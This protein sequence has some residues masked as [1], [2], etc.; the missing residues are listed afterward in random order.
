M[1]MLLVKTN[2]EVVKLLTLLVDGATEEWLYGPVGELGEHSVPLRVTYDVKVAMVTG[3]VMVVV[4][5]V[6][7]WALAAPTEKA[8]INK[9]LIRESPPIVESPRQKERN[10]GSKGQ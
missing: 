4:T 10:L 8:P 2:V 6:V 7:V 9:T 5:T 3:L 1:K